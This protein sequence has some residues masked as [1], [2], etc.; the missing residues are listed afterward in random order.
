MLIGNGR[1][2][3]K[4]PMTFL[5]RDWNG[6]LQPGGLPGCTSTENFGA[7]AAIPDG[8]YQPHGWMLPRKA[9]R[10]AAR[11]RDTAITLGATGAGS[12]GRNTDGVA[13]IV[14]GATGAGELVS[15]T[16]GTA[17]V[18][19]G[20]TGTIFASKS[21]SGTASL[22]L[23]GTAT[24]DAIGHTGGTAPISFAA[25]WAPYAIGWLGGTTAG[26]GLLSE[27]S[28]IAAMNANPP[29]VNIA[30]V[31]DVPVI[32]NGQPGTEWGPV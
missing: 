17:G 29:K 18:S 4:I 7:K 19:F 15:S 23:G 22:A 9:G 5:G 21:T 10:I 2:I 14:F 31:N 1:L 16:S 11:Y 13:G 27:A 32:G 6:Q 12:M 8:Y 20:A 3:D 26:G 30:K 25:S 24:L 28:I